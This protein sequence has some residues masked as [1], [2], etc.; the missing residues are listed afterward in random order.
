MDASEKENRRS[1]FEDLEV[2]QIA[3]EFRKAI[4]HVARRLPDIEKFALANQIRRAAVSLTNNIAEAHG[5][6]HYLDQIKFLRQSRGR[7][8]TTIHDSRFNESR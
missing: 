3:R 1:T 4:Y 8:W 6:Y 2:Y 7:N 5:R